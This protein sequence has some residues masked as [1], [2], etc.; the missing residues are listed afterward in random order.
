[1]RFDNSLQQA[2]DKSAFIQTLLVQN[3]D[4]RL[5]FKQKSYILSGNERHFQ[6]GE[7]TKDILS[8]ANGNP[9]VAGETVYLFLGAE[10]KMNVD[11]ER[12][13]HPIRHESLTESQLINIINK[14]CEP[15]F[16]SLIIHNEYV[17]DVPV[18]IIEIPPSPE[19][20]HLGED[21][22]DAKRTTH[23]RG[24]TFIR[25]GDSVTTASPNEAKALEHI[26]K[27]AFE[28]RA[29]NSCD[30][31]AWSHYWRISTILDGLE[32]PCHC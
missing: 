22:Q 25:T 9:S 16:N 2:K 24:T 6:I 11:G 14:R 26:K 13:I 30:L 3:E 21:M 17:N 5:D 32:Q 27:A 31:V 1:M 20:Y 7:L 23:P 12:G 18:V 28:H 4:G 19:I 29:K 10:D 15:R 8:L